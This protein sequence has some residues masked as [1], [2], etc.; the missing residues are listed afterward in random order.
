M[1]DNGAERIIYGSTGEINRDGLLTPDQQQRLNFLQERAASKLRDYL[2]NKNPEDH[3]PMIAMATGIGKGRITHLVIEQQIRRKPDSKVLVVA[4]TKLVLVDQAHDSLSGY[5]QP[6]QNEKEPSYIESEQDQSLT[7]ETTNTEEEERLL[8]ESHSFL[9]TIGKYGKSDDVNVQIATIQTVQSAL[10]K[11]TLNPEDYDLVVIDEAHNVGT[12]PRL[13]S[14]NQFNRLVGFTA[15][16][17][18][19]SG[20]MKRP[21]QYGFIVIESLPLPEAQ[22]ERFLP[23]LLGLQINTQ[24][25]VDE[26]PVTALGRIDYKKLEQLLKKSPELRPFIA[27]RV[28]NIIKDPSGKNYKTV[29]ACNYVWEAEELAQLLY[30]RGIK[31]GVAINKPVA[32][33]I[34]TEQI[35]AIDSIERYKLPEADEKAIQVLIS[36]YVASEGFDAPF[37]EVLVWAS[38]TDSELR[39]TQ[40]TGRLARRT[41]GKLFGVIVDCLYQTSQYSWS[42]NMAMWMKGNVRQL[43]NGLLYLGPE[44][45]IEGLKNLPAITNFKTQADVKPIRELERKGLFDVKDG[46]IVLSPQS[47]DN[48]IFV[49]DYRRLFQLYSRVK[50]QLE[51]E[52]PEYFTKRINKHFR[53][54]D[55]VTTEGRAVFIK[56]MLEAGVKL[57]DHQLEVVQDTDLVLSQRG[58]MLIF[59]GHHNRILQFVDQV[60]NQLHD[61]HPEYLSRRSNGGIEVEV[62]TAEG[63]E[64][65]I[66]AMVDMGVRIKNNE[67]KKSTDKPDVGL[68]LNHKNLKRLFKGTQPLVVDK[69]RKVIISFKE[70][71]PEYFADRFESP[72]GPIEVLTE[73]GTQVFIQ[74]MIEAGIKLRA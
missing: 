43:E 71:H 11:G 50:K 42:Y 32:K 49:G 51:D 27:D 64:R 34:H 52:H 8:E 2:D 9:Y 40:Y 57:R 47:P 14:I 31:V 60:K 20:S 12:E 61:Q 45:D 58:L 65:F 37:T 26:I 10:N 33:A 66:Q 62:I 68:R 48:V 3:F 38:P 54:V 36:P 7:D 56:A 41:N 74:T 30:D 59:K 1:V 16:P 4:G 35:P 44:T 23:P 21:E 72:R 25:L 46:E 15:T 67:P 28:S 63:R 18:R 24:D 55:V 6:P 29:I 17:Y 53:E 22:E 70:N 73:E 39:Y 69:A 13:E 19:H 5:Q